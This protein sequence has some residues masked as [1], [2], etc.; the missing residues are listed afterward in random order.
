M[1]TFLS[2]LEF[3]GPLFSFFFAATLP[4]PTPMLIA[5]SFLISLGIC[6]KRI[7]VCN[8]FERI[9]LRNLA[10]VLQRKLCRGSTSLPG[11]LGSLCLLSK[12][13]IRATVSRGVMTSVKTSLIPS[14]SYFP[15]VRQKGTKTGKKHLKLETRF[16]NSSCWLG[17][18]EIFFIYHFTH[19]LLLFLLAIQGVS[20][21]Y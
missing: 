15:A 21:A 9:F 13:F 4:Y 11:S 3:Y 8:H 2:S 1:L 5:K 19:L 12:T 14:V 20:L 6:T 17:T 7:A 18:D 10:A 16:P